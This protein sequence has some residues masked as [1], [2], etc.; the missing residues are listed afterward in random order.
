MAGALLQPRP[1]D[2][3]ATRRAL[4]RDGAAGIAGGRYPKILPIVERLRFVTNKRR[5]ARPRAGHPRLAV[6]MAAKAWMAGTVG[7]R[8]DAV[9]RTA[10]PGHDEETQAEGRARLSYRQRSRRSSRAVMPQLMPTPISE[11]RIITAN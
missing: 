7:E 4:C 11:S 2:R 6:L 1:L 9:L 8:S 5:H 10:M 3:H